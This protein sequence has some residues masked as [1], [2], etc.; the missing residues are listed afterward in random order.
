M[1]ATGRDDPDTRGSHLAWAFGDCCSIRAI[2]RPSI[3]RALRIVQETIHAM[4]QCLNGPHDNVTTRAQLNEIICHTTSEQSN[5][6]R[7]CHQW[8]M[9]YEQQNYI[10]MNAGWLLANKLLW[11]KAALLG[12]H[13]IMEYE[14][15]H[16]CTVQ[17]REEHYDDIYMYT[18]VR[19]EAFNTSK[20]HLKS[21]FADQ[22]D[23][24]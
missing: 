16:P 17:G 12:S 24:S 10:L 19:R 4:G 7:T 18:A 13:F 2:N 15:W 3:R 11:P 6:K 14:S 23:N 1:R 5:L 20:S 22:I 8:F 21:E 9:K